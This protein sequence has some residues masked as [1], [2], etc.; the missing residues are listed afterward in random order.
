MVQLRKDNLVLVYGD[1]GLIQPDHEQIYAYIRSLEDQRMLVLLNFSETAASINL[2]EYDGE[3][4][5]NNY[6]SIDIGDGKIT[7]QP[8]Q[9]VIL[10]LS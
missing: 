8:Y 3:I 7:L 1:Y 6:E 2:E 9:S 4:I 5:I 10:K